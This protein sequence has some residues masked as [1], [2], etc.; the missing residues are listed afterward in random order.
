MRHQISGY[1]LGRSSGARVA[2]R[3]N[4]IK[5]FFI[6]ERI[7]TTKTKA[8]A[9]R[10]EAERPIEVGRRAVEQPAGALPAD[11]DPARG[12]QIAGLVLGELF[13]AAPPAGPELEIA[14]LG[15]RIEVT[16]RPRRY[17]QVRLPEITLGARL[18]G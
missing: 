4:L 1:R 2:L 10:G 5:Q 7:Q 18:S 11:V 15:D 16:L 9:I 8:A 14:S 13:R 12:R 6:H 17:A 3:R